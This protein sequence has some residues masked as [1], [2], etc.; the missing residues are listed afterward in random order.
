MIDVKL[1]VNTDVEIDLDYIIEELIDDISFE[2][3]IKFIKKIDKEADNW[4]FTLELYDYFKAQKKIF[5][6]E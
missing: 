2:D 4:D 1:S 5:D 6:K 3:I